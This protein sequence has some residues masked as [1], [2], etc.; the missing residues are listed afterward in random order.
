MKQV[1]AA[2]VMATRSGRGSIPTLA[3]VAMASGANIAAVAA[4]DMI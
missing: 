3:A 1:E 2:S 4:L